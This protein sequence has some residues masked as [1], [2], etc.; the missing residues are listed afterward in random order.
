M[1]RIDENGTI[2]SGNFVKINDAYVLHGQC[3]ITTASGFIYKGH[4]EY[5]KKEGLF[6]ILNCLIKEMIYVTFHDDILINIINN[7]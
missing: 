4:F 7:A 1:M 3:E 6:I 5:G 2:Y